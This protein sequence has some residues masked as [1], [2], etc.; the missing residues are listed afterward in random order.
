MVGRRGADV[1]PQFDS[2]NKKNTRVKNVGIKLYT[3]YRI[4]LQI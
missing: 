2:L 1:G 3:K 4:G